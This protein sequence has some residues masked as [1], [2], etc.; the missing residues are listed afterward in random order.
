MVLL[1]DYEGTSLDSLQQM[2][3]SGLGLAILP[4]CYIRSEAGGTLG[5]RLLDVEGWSATRSIAAAWRGG[6]AY[7]PT[8]QAIALRVQGEARRVLGTEQR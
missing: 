8:Y 6:A 1:R 4:D 3:G 7:A 5:V 2:V